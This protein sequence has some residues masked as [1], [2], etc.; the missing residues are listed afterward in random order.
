[1]LA[2]SIRS[3]W[4]R[5][6]HADVVDE[7]IVLNSLIATKLSKEFHRPDMRSVD[8]SVVLGVILQEALRACPDYEKE[9]SLSLDERWV[10][11][12]II[13]VD[14]KLNAEEQEAYLNWFMERRL[15]SLWPSSSLFFSQVESNASE[16]NW[17]VAS[18]MAKNALHSLRSFVETARKNPV[19]LEP[20][21]LS[22][23]RLVTTDGPG[24]SFFKDHRSVRALFFYGGTLRAFGYPQIRNSQISM[25]AIT[26]DKDLAVSII[27]MVNA[28]QPGSTMSSIDIRTVGELPGKWRAYVS[29]RKRHLEKISPISGFKK[30]RR[31]KLKKGTDESDFSEVAGLL[32]RSLT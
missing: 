9:I 6:A 1:M 11:F 23:A 27:R 32:L 7:A 22:M 15:G 16:Q 13:P 2:I 26:G 8:L 5:Y 12:Q 28:L 3:G 10:D 30:S 19:W 25:G 4:L 14:K 29:S 24:V 18:V 31:I 17:V 20:S 21:T